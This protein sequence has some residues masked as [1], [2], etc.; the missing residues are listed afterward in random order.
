MD[1]KQHVCPSCGETMRW[2]S[3]EIT[4]LVGRYRVKDASG[5]AWCCECGESLVSMEAMS[6]YEKRAARTVMIDVQQVEGDVLK[7]ARKA[8]SLTQAQLGTLLGVASETVSRWENDKDTIGRS[9]QLAVAT[10]LDL[11]CREGD[12]G[13]QALLLAEPEA[14]GPESLRVKVAS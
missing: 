3:C 7:F 12:D 1:N 5:P 14:N 9:T 11:S 10:L 8:M 6:G 4:T 13:I 2:K